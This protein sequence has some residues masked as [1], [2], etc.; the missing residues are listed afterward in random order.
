M[1]ILIVNT[2]YFPE[3][4]GGAEK[5]VQILAEY[6]CKSGHKVNILTLNKSEDKVYSINSV[7]VYSLKIRNVYW[8]FE[9]STKHIPLKYIWHIVDTYISLYKKKIKYFIKH[10]KPDIIHV[11]NISGFGSSTLNYL[12][13]FGKP[14]ILT[15]RD[16]HY[17]CLK[18]TCFNENNCKSLCRYCKFTSKKKLDNLN[19]NVTHVVG[20]SDFILKKYLKHGLSKQINLSKIYNSV[21]TQIFDIKDRNN[22]RNG[23]VFGFIGSITK[24]KGIE[25]LLELF[26]SKDIKHNN[27]SIKI[28]GDGEANYIRQ[29]KARYNSINIEFVGFQDSNHFY[30]NLNA[31]IIPS[32]WQE[33][34][35]RT[36]IE[37]AS[38]G[39]PIFVSK[40]GALVELKKELQNIKW[41]NKTNILDFLNANTHGHY[42][43]DLSMFSP[44][45]ITKEYENL[46]SKLTKHED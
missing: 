36:V 35:G 45:K 10:E 40:N 43:Y 6:L 4:Y 37:G 15:L 26:S 42:K 27:F 11:N 1:N 41:F 16:Y 21:D 13:S 34:F 12:K 19:R 17:L 28:A 22:N 14:V 44:E 9:K 30:S 23:K 46:Y 29:L 3:K 8:P 39:L 32:K 7:K 25:D 5:S 38:F 33:P 31:L 2:L 24:S 20:I 18:N